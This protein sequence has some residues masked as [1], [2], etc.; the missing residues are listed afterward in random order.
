MSVARGAAGSSTTRPSSPAFSSAVMAYLEQVS[1]E[2]IFRAA[3]LHVGPGVDHHVPSLARRRE[4]DVV[5]RRPT[6]GL[7][8]AVRDHLVQGEL[9][10]AALRAAADVDVRDVG[11]VGR[12]ALIFSSMVVP[13]APT[14]TVIVP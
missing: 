14:K 3:A 2:E 8:L 11:G 7:A 13:V 10:A 6:V 12:Q 5:E 1:A 4:L 9:D